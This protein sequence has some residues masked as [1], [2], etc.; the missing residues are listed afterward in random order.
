MEQSLSAWVA[1]LYNENIRQSFNGLS[2]EDEKLLLNAVKDI[3]VSTE[4]Q[5]LIQNIFTR[6]KRAKSRQ[7][8]HLRKCQ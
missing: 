8:K 1:L 7:G 5:Q 4:T 2:S 3:T 6:G